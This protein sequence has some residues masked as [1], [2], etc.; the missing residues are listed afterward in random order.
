LLGEIEDEDAAHPV[1]GKPL[2]HLGEEEDHQSARMGFH[3][4][5]QDWDTGR[6]RN[7]D[8]QK[9]NN[10]HKGGFP[11]PWTAGAPWGRFTPAGHIWRE[12]ITR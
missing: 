2:P 5:Q 10:I 4:L 9:D 7:D 1:V 11:I 3:Q 8:P 6:Q 12:K